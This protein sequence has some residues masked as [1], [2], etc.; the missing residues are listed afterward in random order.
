MSTRGPIGG[1]RQSD[2]WTSLDAPGVAAAAIAKL[3]AIG[4][5]T[6]EVAARDCYLGLLDLRPGQTVLDVGAGTGLIQDFSLGSCSRNCLYESA[7]IT[8]LHAYFAT[9][10]NSSLAALTLLRAASF[11]VRTASPDVDWPAPSCDTRN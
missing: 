6:A 8:S 3:E 4:Q 2:D 11:I 1:R 7:N 9:A 10:A 5:S